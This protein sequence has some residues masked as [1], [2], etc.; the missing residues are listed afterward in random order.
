MLEFEPGRAFLQ[1][2]GVVQGGAVC[3]MLDFAAACAT[4]SVLP[5]GQDCATVTLTSSFLR[6]VP[7]GVLQAWAEIEKRGRTI[8]FMRASIALAS[9]P[10]HVLATANVVLAV[11][12]DARGK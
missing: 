5:A 7:L 9:H 2:E 4:M 8:V 3:A 6:P 10:E 11:L 1:G 12:G